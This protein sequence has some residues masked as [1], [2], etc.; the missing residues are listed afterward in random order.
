[1]GWFLSGP[2]DQVPDRLGR[3]LT[4][5]SKRF[6][7]V[8]YT[9][10]STSEGLKGRWGSYPLTTVSIPELNLSQTYRY[11]YCC[12][13]RA[14]VRQGAFARNRDSLRCLNSSPRLKP[15]ARRWG[16]VRQRSCRVSALLA[17]SDAM[18]L[19]G[20]KANELWALPERVE[21]L[22]LDL[23]GFCKSRAAS[24][25]KACSNHARVYIGAIS[26]GLGQAEDHRCGR[27]TACIKAAQA[28]LRLPARQNCSSTGGSSTRQ[29]LRRRPAR[30]SLTLS[31][32]ASIR[33]PRRQVPER[34]HT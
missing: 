7:T 16:C 1:M 17:I 24:S 33:S 31:S 30:P 12:A 18:V 13:E 3:F 15:S 10:T 22:A 26:K 14:R 23:H 19:M 21:A 2:A 25:A 27:A 29:L 34:D 5:V 6:R 8:A 4:C 9:S 32:R 11:R 20:I 28:P